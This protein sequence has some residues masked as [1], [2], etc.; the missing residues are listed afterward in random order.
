MTIKW[1]DAWREML[2]WTIGGICILA[3]CLIATFPYT[4]LQN[5]LVAELKRATGLDI[6]MAEWTIGLPMNVEWRNV[7][8][9]TPSLDPVELAMVQAKLG[10]LQALNGTLGLDV[11][12]QLNEHSARSSVV[13][14]TLTAASLSLAGPLTLKGQL[15]QVELPKLIRR[16]VT[17][18]TLSGEFSLRADSDP[19][20][21]NVL[22]PE[23]TLT[24]EATNLEVDQIPLNNGKTLSLTF[25][26][27][28]AG[29]SCRNLV[30]DVTQLRAEGLDASF[31]GQGQITLQHQI[32]NSQL[33]LTVTLIPGPGFASKAAALG[34]PPFP[35][36][37]PITVKIVGT[38]AQARIAL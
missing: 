25:N 23:G 38:L 26:S 20:S 35:P 7:S 12:V 29:L 2:A 11:L 19:S 16:Y 27:A 1:P 36:G 4:L 5:R 10:I 3:L 15:Q 37:T 14:G 17:R 8:V 21:P 9:S 34:L 33:A 31:E 28:A 13:K 18:G 24:A 22:K 6:R 32:P 30:C